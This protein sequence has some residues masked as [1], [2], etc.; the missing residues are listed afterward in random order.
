MRDVLGFAALFGALSF[1]LLG[2]S[3]LDEDGYLKLLGVLF[4]VCCPG[5][6]LVSMGALRES[7]HEGLARGANWVFWILAGLI[8]L[9][10][11]SERFGGG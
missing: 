4:V 5:L 11:L 6:L 10:S 2:W 7:R 8:L 3:M 1:G 9:M